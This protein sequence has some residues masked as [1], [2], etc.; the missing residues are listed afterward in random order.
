[1]YD[2]NEIDWTDDALGNF[3]EGDYAVIDKGYGSEIRVT[4]IEIEEETVLVEDVQGQQYPVHILR[5][6]KY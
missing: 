4:V 2:E 5:L 6:S 1:M 3:C